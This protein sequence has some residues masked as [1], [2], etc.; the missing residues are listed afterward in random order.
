MYY[1]EFGWK[2]LK[3][4]TLEVWDKEKK[5][6]H[7]PL[8]QSDTVTKWCP[9]TEDTRTSG[10]K[11]GPGSTFVLRVF[12]CLF[13]FNMLAIYLQYWC[14][15]WPFEVDQISQHN[16]SIFNI[17]LWHSNH[18]QSLSL[19]IDIIYNKMSKKKVIWVHLWCLLASSLFLLYVCAHTATAFAHCYHQLPISETVWHQQQ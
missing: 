5:K 3:K 6:N 16:K 18:L 12:F 19:D 2:L 11:A 15:Y 9:S 7:R 17:S 10:K 13:I 14:R 8:S 1:L 4:Q